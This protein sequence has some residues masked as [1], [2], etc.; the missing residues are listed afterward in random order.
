MA[1]YGAV[2]P[3]RSMDVRAP[4]IAEAGSNSPP[5]LDIS[6]LPLGTRWRSAARSP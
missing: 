3:V 5:A 2:G 6:G 4:G 1:S